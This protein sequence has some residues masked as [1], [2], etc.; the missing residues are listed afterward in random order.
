M[1]IAFFSPAPFS[2]ILG[3]TKNRIELGEALNQIGWESSFIGNELLGLPKDKIITGTQYN[4]ALKDFLL[5][6]AAQYDVIVYEYNSLPFDREM[7]SKNTLFVARPAILN[8]H[9]K[10]VKIKYDLKSKVKNFYNAIKTLLA[11]QNKDGMLDVATGETSM[12]NC[13]LMQVQNSFDAA[14]LKNK[15]P[16]KKIIRV[17]NGI[18]RDRYDYFQNIQHNYNNVSAAPRIAYVGTFDFRKGAMDFVT[19]V[20]EIKRAYPNV[21]FKMIGTKGMFQTV[22]K[23]LSF[24]PKEVRENIVVIPEFEPNELPELLRDC[25]LG[26][27]PS[28]IESFGFGA[29][30]MMCSGLPVVGYKCAGPSDFLIKDLLL[31]IGDTKSLIEKVKSLIA[32]DNLIEAK[33][34]EA[35]KI[36]E[37]FNWDKIAKKVDVIYRQE[38]INKTVV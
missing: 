21:I 31:E 28:Y 16:D 15:F 18:G 12:Q 3:A 4:N 33:S 36:A 9:F 25:H 29:L 14:I 37:E 8:Y 17:P 30:E 27:F 13:D 32:D 22:E 23:V 7:F 34:V 6:N 11:P 35:K 26:V 24:F 10:S 5:K 38:L 2:R 19:I 1:K 20:K